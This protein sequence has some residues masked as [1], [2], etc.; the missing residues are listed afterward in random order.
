MT[1]GA[2][3]AVYLIGSGQGGTMSAGAK[4]ALAGV[5]GRKPRVAASYAAMDGSGRG[6]SFMVG[7]AAKLFGVDVER[8]TVPGERGAGSEKDAGT[9]AKADLVFI[10]GGDPVHGARLFTQSGADAW[11]REASERGVRCSASAR[12]R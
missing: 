8:F 11:L 12:A 7:M 4:R 2:R 10:A 1:K 3:G 6:M 9:L 5:Q